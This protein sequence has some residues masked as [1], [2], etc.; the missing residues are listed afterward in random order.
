MSLPDHPMQ[1][2]TSGENVNE[3]HFT[4]SKKNA[5]GVCQWYLHWVDS[6]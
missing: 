1:Q 6:E 5:H 4:R 3:C 2:F